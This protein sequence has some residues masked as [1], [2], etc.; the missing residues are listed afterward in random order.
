[1]STRMDAIFNDHGRVDDSVERPP[2]RGGLERILQSMQNFATVSEGLRILGAAVLLAS[3]SIFLLQGWSEGND[4]S[5]YMLLLSQ[6]G[7]LAAGGFAL[8]HGLK[9][10]K[11]ARLFFGLAIISIPANFTILSALIYSI[12]QWDGGL[13]TY[14]DYA[15][16]SIGNA[17]SIGLTLGGALLVLIPV[18]MFCFAIMARRSAVTLSVHFLLINGLLLLPIRS[19]T[20]VG[21]VALIGTIYALLVVGKL[22]RKDGALAT[23]EGKF[24]LMTLFIPGAVILI[25]S[26]YFYQVSSLLIAMLSFALF[27]IARQVSSLPDRKRGIALLMDMLSLPVALVAA[28]SLTIGL[29][30]FIAAEFIAPVFAV[31]FALLAIDLIRRT[32]SKAV[33]ATASFAISAFTCL[34]FVISVN[35]IT[36][37][38]TAFQ[39][40]IV[41]VVLA[42]A[43]H[44]LKNRVA[45]FAGTVT[46]LA[47]LFLG[48]D[49]FVEMI[50]RSSWVDLAIFGASAITLG[51]IL[52]RHGASLKLRLKKL[53]K[54]AS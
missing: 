20:A 8:S 52:D 5:R 9:E 18:T 49:F 46:V 47:G 36:N 41:G 38:F 27:L 1:M 45:M 16:W 19:S 7:L 28:T 48:F 10:A 22:A 26:M 39:C 44:S 4:I 17:A 54:L 34:G 37:P 2:R 15:T 32:D 21:V 13:I 6:T 42:M 40:L 11:G 3:M 53:L 25:R 43:G 12:M 23:P 51:S 30:R 24:A 50:L 29:E 35:V 14:P 31:S 33:S